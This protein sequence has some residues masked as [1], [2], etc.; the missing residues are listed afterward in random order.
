MPGPRVQSGTAR[1]TRLRRPVSD[2]GLAEERDV[3]VRAPGAQ[4]A[5]AQLDDGGAGDQQRR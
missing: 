4:D 5:V 3:D 1:V 2:D